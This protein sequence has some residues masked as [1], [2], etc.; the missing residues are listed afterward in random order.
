M[1]QAASEDVQRFERWAD[2]YETSFLQKVL[3][4]RVHRVVL[5]LVPA[6]LNPQHVLDVGCGTGRLLRKVRARWPAAR[7]SGV[8]A[9]QGMIAM[10][11]QA[12]P[13]CDFYTAPAEALPLADNAIDLA[14]STVSF[15]HW[16]DQPQ[17]LREVARVLRPGGWL[18]LA[19]MQIPFGLGAIIH[20]GKPAAPHTACEMLARAGLRP[21]TRRG[22]FGPGFYIL[23]ATREQ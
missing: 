17:G 23:G 2:T 20:H 11:R 3:F 8:D 6:G 9:A 15:H 16:A 5:E 14:L 22:L 18:I 19:D 13:E 1:K 7:L 4:D 12:M 21:V 10:A